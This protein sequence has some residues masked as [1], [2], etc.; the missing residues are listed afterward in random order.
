[1]TARPR[2]AE[3]ERA[4]VLARRRLT[5]QR[6]GLSWRRAVTREAAQVHQVDHG[7][8][9]ISLRDL[10][11]HGCDCAQ[12]LAQAAEFRRYREAKKSLLAKRRDARS[13]ELGVLIGLRR[14]R[15]DLVIGDRAGSS[16]K[17]LL[18]WIQAIHE[19]S[20]QTKV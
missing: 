7:G 20:C 11:E 1:M 5:E 14:V 13:D 9:G 17:L 16:G 19:C 15:R 10:F 4:Q 6:A 8:R 3:C 18:L 12:A 2:L